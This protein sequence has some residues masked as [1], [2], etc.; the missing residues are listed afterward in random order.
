MLRERF[1]ECHW[2]KAVW[3]KF[4]TPKY[5]FLLWTA[6]KER[7]TTRDRMLSWN[8]NIDPS[9]VFCQE[10]ME[11]R[12][13]IFFECSFSAQIWEALMGGVLGDQYTVVWDDLMRMALDT[14]QGKI[15]LF[16]IRYVF[17]SAIHSIWR[18][19]NRRRH[20][21]SPSPAE[22]LIRML[23]K[24]IRNRF[25]VIREKGK[26]DYEGGMAFWFATRQNYTNGI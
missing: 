13:H 12:G 16:V 5:S 11:T 8:R 23:D 17:Q 26:G 10:P 9:C 7:L 22:L 4:A 6:I 2:E 15:K 14:T 25:T 24:N 19:R 20:G 18:E 1:I 3:F 21:E